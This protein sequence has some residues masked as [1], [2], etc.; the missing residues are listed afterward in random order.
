MDYTIDI[1]FHFNRSAQSNLLV[2]VIPILVYDQ[3]IDLIRSSMMNMFTNEVAQMI[4]NE[5]G[6]SL[7]PLPVF[8]SS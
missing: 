6:K 1:L 4:P 2:N 8:V 5:L 7:T 3:Q